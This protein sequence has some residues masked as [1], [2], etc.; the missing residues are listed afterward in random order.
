MIKTGEGP[1]VA[2]RLMREPVIV[3]LS[4][5]FA[6]S[7]ASSAS[8]CAC[9]GETSTTIS[10]GSPRRRIHFQLAS[11]FINQVSLIEPG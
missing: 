9:T 1:S 6:S 10:N 3:T 8:V 2:V 4:S 7:I 11:V 5:S